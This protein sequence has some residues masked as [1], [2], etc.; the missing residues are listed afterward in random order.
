MGLFSV[1]YMTWLI[2]PFTTF[3]LC[4]TLSLSKH[5]EVR[6]LEP[7]GQLGDSVQVEGLTRKDALLDELLCIWPVLELVFQRILQ[8]ASLKFLL[9]RHECRRHIGV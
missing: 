7:V 8:L 6:P 1:M 5:L 4:T 2:H 9:C 3:F